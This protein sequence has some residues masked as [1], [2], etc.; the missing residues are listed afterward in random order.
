[1]SEVSQQN[2]RLIERFVSEF[3]N[4]GDTAKAAEFVSTEAIFHVPGAPEPLR[5]PDGYTALVG[6]LR[7]GAPDIGWTI[8]EIVADDERV[9]AR[10]TMSGTHTGPLF[11]VPATG[12]RFSA[13][14][15]GFYEIT[16]GKIVAEHGMPDMLS[17]LTQLGAIPPAPNA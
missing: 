7:H 12:K 2:R 17:I 13:L 5:G 15:M 14:S 10:F 1:M 11:G 16:G 6:M 9:A 3:I 4:K 8:E